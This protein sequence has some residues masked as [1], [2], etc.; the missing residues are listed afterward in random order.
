M[1]A[2]CQTRPGDAQV[3]GGPGAGGAVFLRL[4]AALVTASDGAFTTTVR[5]GACCAEPL[6]DAAAVRASASSAPARQRRDVGDWSVFTTLMT[7]HIPAGA[8]AAAKSP[9]SITFSTSRLRIPARR[10]MAMP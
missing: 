9:T 8:T 3:S 5:T 6:Q 4:P 1:L 2:L 7:T 10:A